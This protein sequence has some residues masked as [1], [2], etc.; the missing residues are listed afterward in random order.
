MCV[1]V[2]FH[3]LVIVSSQRFG[4]GICL[5]SLH[6]LVLHCVLFCWFSLPSAN[7]ERNGFK[8]HSVL[9]RGWLVNEKPKVTWEATVRVA[10]GRSVPELSSELSSEFLSSPLEF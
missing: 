10:R 5:I 1:F 7:G 2:C 6:S 4:R 9:N 3:R 8:D